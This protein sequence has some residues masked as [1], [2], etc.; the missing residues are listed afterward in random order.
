MPS[1]SES[2]VCILH[3]KIQICLDKHS[4]KKWVLFTWLNYVNPKQFNWGHGKSSWQSPFLRKVRCLL[5][6]VLGQYLKYWS[7]RYF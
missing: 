3:E 5:T 7:T 6:A 1:T 4:A 2:P